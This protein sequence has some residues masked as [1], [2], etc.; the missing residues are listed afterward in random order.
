[1]R[2]WRCE[3][4]YP[5]EHR[6]FLALGLSFTSDF[7]KR[8]CTQQR[9]QRGEQIMRTTLFNRAAGAFA[10]ALTLIGVAHSASA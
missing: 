3:T 1:M 8:R 5:Y 9:R 6:K 2:G 4:L 7:T 10:A